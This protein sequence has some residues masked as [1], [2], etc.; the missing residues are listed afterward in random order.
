MLWP[1]ANAKNC[2]VSH[3]QYPCPSTMPCPGA[4]VSC[5][6]SGNNVAFSGNLNIIQCWINAPNQNLLR[7]KLMYYIYNGIFSLGVTLVQGSGPTSLTCTRIPSYLC[8]LRDK[9]GN[10]PYMTLHS[11]GISTHAQHLYGDNIPMPILLPYG[12]KYLCTISVQG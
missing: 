1:Q 9:R 8:S 3:Q 2:T 12:D 6:T 5:I 7:W 11:M 4:N 10:S